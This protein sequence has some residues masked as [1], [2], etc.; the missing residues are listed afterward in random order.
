LEAG[1]KLIPFFVADRP[2]SLKILRGS[3]LEDYSVKVGLMSHANTSRNFQELFSLYP[4]T[5]ERYCEIAGGT[6]PFDRSIKKCPKGSIVRRNLVKMCDS[7][8]FQKGGCH[9]KYEELFSTYENMKPAYG[10]IIDYLRQKDK[11]IESA[12]EAYKLYG[13]GN[14]SFELVG[15]SQG[16]TVDEYI[17]CYNELKKIGYSHIAIGGLLKKA[18]NSVRFVMVHSEQLLNEV[19][20]AV[21]NQFPDDWLFALGCYRLKRHEFLSSM[22]IFGSDYKGWIFNY[23][24]GRGKKD[25]KSTKSRTELRAIRF[26]QTRC[27]VRN[28]YRKAQSLSSQPQESNNVLMHEVQ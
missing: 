8:M 1:K 9:L 4:C 24:V 28:V 17:E 11:T 18:E 12:K 19:F 26:R 6:C 21:R 27:H 14:Y 10:I 13:K 2:A 7:G 5:R 3:K 22:R 16:A 25:P 23:D 20:L 15:V